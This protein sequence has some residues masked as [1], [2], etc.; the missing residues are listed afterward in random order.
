MIDGLITPITNEE[1]RKA[2][3]A[4]MQT[5]LVGVRTQLHNSLALLSDHEDPKY[6]DSIK[7]SIS[8]VESMCRHIVNDDKATLGQALKQ[9]KNAGI[10]I[11]HSLEL[12]FG[13]LYGYT[14]DESGIRHALIGEDCTYL[15]DATYMLVTC[16][17]FINYL[18]VKAD[19]AGI[20]I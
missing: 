18:V 4:A 12:A 1:E 15:E 16:S 17:A 6:G 13:Q 19:K 7:N 3:E 11:H 9:L 14:S 5:P 8:A 20:K 10:R 2:I